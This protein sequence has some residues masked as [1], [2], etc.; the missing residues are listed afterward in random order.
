ML[1]KLFL[2]P[3]R[4]EYFKGYGETHNWT[5]KCALW[6]DY[7]LAPDVTYGTAQGAVWNDFWV[8]FFKVLS[9]THLTLLMLDF[10]IAE[11]ILLGKR[12]HA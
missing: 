9:V 10:E 4:P 8:S 5:H 7:A 12:R 1:D 2:D 6:A 11:T 3:K